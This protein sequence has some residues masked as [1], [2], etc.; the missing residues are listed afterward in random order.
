MLQGET[1]KIMVDTAKSICQVESADT[2]GLVL[3]AGFVEDGQELQVVFCASWNSI[4]KH[5]LHGC[6][7]VVVPH[8]VGHPSL[9]HQTSEHFP[10]Q[11]VK[12]MGRKLVGLLG[13]SSA[14]FFPRRRMTPTFKASGTLC[15]AQQVLKMC[16]RA[17][18]SEEHLLRT[19]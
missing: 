4:D 15:S 9:F 2:E 5:F 18:V 16:S 7:E 3:S 10:M 17:G 8:H 6:V 13:S 11:D 14:F 12:A 1:N 19:T